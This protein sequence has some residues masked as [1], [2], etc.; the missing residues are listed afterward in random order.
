MSD[1]SKILIA[2]DDLP[3]VH[4]LCDV[5]AAYSQYEV[6]TATAKG[7]EI[8]ALKKEKIA[9]LVVNLNA[10]RLDALQVLSLVSTAYRHVQCIV[11]LDQNHPSL[12]KTASCLVKDSVFLYITKPASLEIIGCAILEALQR[13]DE[14][15][16]LPGIAVSRVLSFF[17]VMGKTCRVEVRFGTKK[18]GFLDFADG[19]LINAVCEKKKGLEAAQEIFDWPPLGFTIATDEY[20]VETTITPSDLETVR[21]T[22]RLKREAAAKGLSTAAASPDQKITLFIVDDSKMMRKV[23]ANIF[24]DD[25]FVKVVGEAE[26]GEEALELIPQLKPDVVTLDV[27]MPVMDG[28]KTIK[29]LMIQAPTPTVMLSSMTQD[30][31]AVTFDALKYGAVDFV[32]KPSRN[33]EADLNE[34]TRDIMRKVHLAA[35]VELEAVRYVRAVSKD[36]QAVFPAGSRCRKAVAIGAAEGGYGA[37]LKLLPHLSANVP[38]AYLIMFYAP[39]RH[40][41][42]FVE[43]MDQLTPLRTVR[44]QNNLPLE[45]GTCYFASGEEYLTVHQ[46]ADGLVLH[47]SAA[48]FASQ[49]GSVNMLFFSVAEVLQENAVAVVLSGM[50]EDGTEGMAEVLRVGGAGLIQDPSGCLYRDMPRSAA[51]RCPAAKVLP[52]SGISEAVNNLLALKD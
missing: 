3:F 50:G 10:S 12:E 48:P 26:N 52:D 28:L 40:L 29:R 19:V 7:D 34:Q 2:D 17:E 46:Q 8:F 9:V 20:E 47:L 45:A 5:L 4:A 1:I 24:K 11:L 33:A 6:L 43:Y 16:Y 32:A 41:D 21:V 13:L 44:A 51:D 39:S 37:L 23:I 15:D 42:S 36:K 49:R 35:E 14:N 27:E 18:Q 22:S 25:P 31:A 30:G 38:A